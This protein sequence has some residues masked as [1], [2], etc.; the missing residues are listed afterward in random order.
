MPQTLGDDSMNKMNYTLASFLLDDNVRAVL[1]NYDPADVGKKHRYCKT[2]D[3]SIKP[4]DLVIVPTT[5][6]HGFT[7]CKVMEVDV[8]PPLDSDDP[9]SWIVG[10]VDLD[11]YERTKKQDDADI[12]K[13]KAR[14][15]DNMRRQMRAAMFAD[16]VV[17]PLQPFK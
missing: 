5:T 15:L 1:V 11:A 9:I 14:R 2:T 12:A 17:T 13:V 16:D 10:T 4:D 6:R 3:R 8:E 7:V